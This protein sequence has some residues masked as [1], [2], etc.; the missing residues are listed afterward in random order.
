MGCWWVLVN[1]CCFFVW[2]LFWSL[3]LSQIGGGFLFIV[4]SIES[5]D[6]TG[7]FLNLGWLDFD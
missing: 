1:D 5:V 6:C 7:P 2:F 3:P 4:V